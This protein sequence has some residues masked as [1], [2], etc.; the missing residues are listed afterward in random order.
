[1]SIDNFTRIPKA[2]P[3]MLPEMIGGLKKIRYFSL[4]YYGNKATWSD[5]RCM[6]TF[7]FYSVYQFLINHM[8][9]DIYLWLYHLGSDDDYPTH[10]L[11][12]DRNDSQMYIG[13]Y[14]QVERFLDS[15]HPPRQPI[16]PEQWSE[17]KSQIE[18]VMIHW[19]ESDFKRRGMFEMFGNI[20]P[21]Q[22][23]EQI[24]LV[25][26]LDQQV[27]DDLL[28]QYIKEAYSGNYNAIFTLK[29]LQTRISAAKKN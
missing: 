6:G 11:L 29:Q 24:E 4:C 27:T 23:R 21:E 5:G 26:W 2:L 13:E 10:V 25:H 8:A 3:P 20:T 14:K 7:S 18:D 12:C 17:I 9:L 16:T 19:T 1:M 28:R 22:R 15:Q